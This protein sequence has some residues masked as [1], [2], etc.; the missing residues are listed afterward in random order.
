ML[1]GVVAECARFQLAGGGL[2][3]R[4]DAGDVLLAP[5]P[6]SFSAALECTKIRRH[7]KAGGL[8]SVSSCGRSARR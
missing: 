7:A 6:A 3:A 4:A 2:Q 1:C 5:L 8:G